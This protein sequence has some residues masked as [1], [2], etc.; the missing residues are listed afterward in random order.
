MKR[1]LLIVGA[2]CDALACASCGTAADGGS[3]LDGLPT[4]GGATATDSASPGGSDGQGGALP[5]DNPPNAGGD[6]PAGNAPNSSGVDID[7]TTMSGTLVYAEVYNIMM[8]PEEYM[9]KT[10]K[11]SGPYYSSYY[12]KT[13]LYY[14]YV[15]VEDAA[16]CC[17]QGLEFIWEGDHA[18]PDDYPADA[19]RVE[20][21]GEFGSYDELGITYYYRSVDDITRLGG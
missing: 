7:L 2:L 14:H 18:F 5:W 15:I 12:D 20:V 13:D 3:P 1:F 4:G 21:V 6:S 19:T 8:R 11:M 10:I 9:G 16:A 17:Q